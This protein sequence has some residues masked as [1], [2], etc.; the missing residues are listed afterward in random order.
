MS[1]S[2]HP[3]VRGY[4]RGRPT[5]LALMSST[6]AE[7][8]CT[9]CI[10]GRPYRTGVHLPST[11]SKSHLVSVYHSLFTQP[12][13]AKPRRHRT[14]RCCRLERL[15]LQHRSSPIS[16]SISVDNFTNCSG[17][18]DRHRRRLIGSIRC[19]IGSKSSPVR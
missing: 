5:E 12:S 13:K 15:T 19:G 3:L 6:R 2:I 18:C 4:N 10:L 8:K 1:S 14:I 9:G 16:S 11:G 17:R 7:V